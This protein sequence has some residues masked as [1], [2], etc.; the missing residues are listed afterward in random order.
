[1][2][3]NRHGHTGNINFLEAVTSDKGCTDIGGNGNHRDGIHKCGGNTGDQI[4]SARSGCCKA[5]AY[6]A[7]CPGITICRM[8]ST[9][10]MCGQDMADAVRILIQLIINIEGCTARITENGIGSLF[11]QCLKQNL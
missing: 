10:L 1:M 4:S 5:Y 11:Q 9:L 8:G 3:G 7:G 6:L 2:L